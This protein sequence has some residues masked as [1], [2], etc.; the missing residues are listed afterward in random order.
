[1][2][3]KYKFS[4]PIL[5]TLLADKCH[6]HKPFPHQNRRFNRKN[7]RSLFYL[8]KA[9]FYPQSLFYPPKP[10]STHT[11]ALFLSKARYSPKSPLHKGP[12]PAPSQNRRFNRKNKR[13]LF[14]LHK[15]R[16]YPRSLFYLHKVRFYLQL[17]LIS[18]TIPAYFLLSATSAPL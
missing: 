11:S 7:K 12:F 10:V 13:S 18:T 9:Y 1:M 6:K 5:R 2:K 3:E 17:W 8:H 16:F 14:Y 4:K 15:V